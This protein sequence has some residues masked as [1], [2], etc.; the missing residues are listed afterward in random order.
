MKSRHERYAYTF[1]GIINA[2]IQAYSMGLIK[3][4]DRDVYDTCHQFMHGIFS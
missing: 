1:L 3:L 4:N 2:S